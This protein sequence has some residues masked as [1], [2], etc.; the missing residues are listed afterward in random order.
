MFNARRGL[1]RCLLFV[2]LFACAVTI[3]GADEDPT[4]LRIGIFADLHAHDTDSPLDRFL[5][6]DWAERLQACVDAMNAWPADLMIELGDFINGRFVLGAELGD[7]ERIPAILSAVDAVY[8]AFDGPRYYVLGN[9]DVGDLTKAEF[10][11][12]VGAEAT[13]SSFD[14]GG[15]H[16]VLLDAQYREDG[17]DRGREFWYMTGFIPEHVLDWL[18]DD[19]ASSELPTIVCLHQRLDLEFEIRHGGPEV[20]NHEEVRELLVGDG[21]VI[22]VFQGHDHGGG[23]SYVD[24]IH[25]VTFTALIGRIGGKPPTW[26]Y[27]TLDPTV[28][29]IEIVGE[30]EQQDLLLNY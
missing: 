1:R 10:L 25:Y 2:A 19:L 15:V 6:V 8:A 30:G 3:L 21:D 20:L 14:V 28:R 29:T 18:R 17:S 12:H 13:T 16:V 22:A 24:G 11:E 7:P 5:M 9:H 27:V 4:P 26:A 23:Y